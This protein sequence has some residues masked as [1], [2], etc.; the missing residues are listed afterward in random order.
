MAKSDEQIVPIEAKPPIA[1]TVKFGLI[2]ICL[3]FGGFMF[4]SVMAPIESAAIAPG[5]VTV[6]SNRK[7]IQHLEG[8]IVKELHVRDGA[9]VKKGDL[10]IRLED[11]QAKASFELLRGQSIELLAAEARLKAERDNATTLTFPEI[12]LKNKDKPEVQAIMKSQKA[13]FETNKR[14]LAGH[15]NILGQRKSQLEKEIESL[16]AQ[17]NS[18]TKQLKLIEEEIKAV[19][20]LEKRKLIEK[21]RLLA[22]QREAA[23]LLGDRGEHIGLIAK[24]QQK[25]GETSMQLLTTK[26]KYQKDILDQLRDT[27]QRLADILQRTKAA[28]DVLT[29]IEIKAPQSG[30]VV[31]LTAHTIGGVISPGEDVLHI[32]P[33]DDKLIVEARVSPLD[34]DVVH[35]GLLAKVQFTAFKQ[36]STPVVDGLVHHISADSFEDPNTKESYYKARIGI[37]KEQMARLKGVKLYPGMP[38]Q[39]MIIIDKQSPF[40]YF[41]TPIKDSFSRAFREQ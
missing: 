17:V 23:R 29:R 3:F 16:D 37:S 2:V 35:E 12:L 30:K 32:I 14:T 22:L 15:L 24:A 41:V 25:I 26:D 11:T 1:D 33:S 31:G 27:Q 40:S 18:E 20:Y 4:W 7:T 38:A 13:I 28:Q 8:G 36:R 6:D 19:A 9:V 21:P 34:I 5:K 39:V 10:L